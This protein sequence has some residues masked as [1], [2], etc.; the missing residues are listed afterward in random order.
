MPGHFIRIITFLWEWC[1]CLL[2]AIVFGD[3]KKKVQKVQFLVNIVAILLLEKRNNWAPSSE[4]VSSS[5]PSWQSLTAHAQ[6][7]RGARDLAFCL[8]V[9][10]DSLLIWASSEG[11][12]ETAR[13]CRL[14]WTFA[15]RIGYKYQN[16]LDA[17][18]IVIQH[19]S[20]T[21]FLF[22]GR[23]YHSSVCIDLH[24]YL[25]YITFIIVSQRKDSETYFIRLY[26]STNIRQWALIRGWYFS[27]ICKNTSHFSSPNLG[28]GVY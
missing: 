22:S 17:V 20:N 2:E 12:G 1:W 5:I 24:E 10:L 8:K 16:L 19:A 6:P 21:R 15:A 13:M 3:G 23:T 26:F 4:F 7:F 27:K 25:T 14:A 28:V 9:P 11:S 18:H